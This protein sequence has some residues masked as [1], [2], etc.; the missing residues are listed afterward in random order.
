MMTAAGW[1]FMALFW[2]FILVF[3][4]WCFK[5]VLGEKASFGDEGPAPAKAGAE[6]ASAAA[7]P[8]RQ[9]GDESAPAAAEAEPRAKDGPGEGDG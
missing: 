8:V 1:T 3:T 9:A 5:L 7:E 6:P 4:A 2:G